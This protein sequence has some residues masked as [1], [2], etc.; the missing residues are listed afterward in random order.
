MA[1]L[2][3]V[4]LLH[5]GFPIANDSLELRAPQLGHGGLP[6]IGV[7]FLEVPCTGI[8]CYLGFKEGVPP[9]VGNAH[10]QSLELVQRLL[11]R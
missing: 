7:P 5:L 8:L 3:G 2:P 1:E 9:I 4:H 11:W 10:I 6:N